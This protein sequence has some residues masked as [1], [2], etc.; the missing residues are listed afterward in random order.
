[1]VVLWLVEL[2]GL[3]GLTGI[4]LDFL[5]ADLRRGLRGVWGLAGLICVYESRTKPRYRV[6]TQYIP[7]TVTPYTCSSPSHLSRW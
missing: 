1:M 5:D 6:H 7:S 4:G 3:T 2:A